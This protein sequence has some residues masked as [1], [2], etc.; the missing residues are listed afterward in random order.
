MQKPLK[1][2]ASVL[3]AAGTI[4]LVNVSPAQ[5][6]CTGAGNTMPGGGNSTFGGFTLGNSYD[7]GNGFCFT[8]NSFA[9]GFTSGNSLIV[10]STPTTLGLSSSK[11]TPG[12]TGNNSFSY[13]FSRFSPDPSNLVIQEYTGTVASSAPPVNNSTATMTFN[14]ASGPSITSNGFVAFGVNLSSSPSYVYPTPSLRSETFTASMSVTAG[15]MNQ[16]STSTLWAPPVTTPT[17]GPLP[18]LGAGAA[19]GFSRKLRSRIKLSA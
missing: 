13:T 5:A 17:P 7:A 8:L 11:P 3:F 19:F 16:F 2:G 18:L 4:A 14:A 12:F 6:A 10:S 1:L 9:S 15:Q